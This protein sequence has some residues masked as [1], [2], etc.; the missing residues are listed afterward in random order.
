[1]Q[2]AAGDAFSRLFQYRQLWRRHLTSRG[3]A[4]DSTD[5]I[6]SGDAAV[7]MDYC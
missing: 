4:K 5:R 3:V 6:D 2:N 1:M 7:A